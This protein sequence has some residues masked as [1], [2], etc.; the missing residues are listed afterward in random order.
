VFANVPTGS[1]PNI[2]SSVIRAVL[3]AGNPSPPSAAPPTFGDAEEPL[4]SPESNPAQSI[5]TCAPLLIA[6]PTVLFNQTFVYNPLD[7]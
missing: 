1:I 2:S 4:P 6:S 5:S 3:P 7:K